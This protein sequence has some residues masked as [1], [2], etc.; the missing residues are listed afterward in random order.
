MDKLPESKIVTRF[1]IV[2]VTQDAPF[3]ADQPVGHGILPN[4]AVSQTLDD[5]LKNEDTQL[6][7]ALRLAAKP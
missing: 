2:H 1:S 4:V 7:E 6:N 5:F 3:R